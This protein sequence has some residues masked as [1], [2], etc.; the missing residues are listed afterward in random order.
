MTQFREILRM[1]SAGIFN[2]REIAQSL[3]LSHNTVARTPDKARKGAEK[4]GRHLANAP[5]GIL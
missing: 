5:D 1:A 3:K 4:D 2:Q